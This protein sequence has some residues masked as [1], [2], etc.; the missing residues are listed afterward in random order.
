M[1]APGRDPNFLYLCTATSKSLALGRKLPADTYP[2]HARSPWSEALALHRRRGWASR[3]RMDRAAQFA[4]VVALFA[5]ACSP[6]DTDA[7]RE[8]GGA[9]RQAAGV[10]AE[11]RFPGERW[12]NIREKAGIGED[13]VCA[14]I[15]GQ[16][17]I[18]REKRALLMAQSD[19]NP[20]TWKTLYENWC[21]NTP[22][23]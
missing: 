18:Y 2:S 19:F 21:L 6:A 4:A 22:Y 10:A 13:A 3:S 15:A 1:S 23:R 14:E 17:I 9:L 20:D 16:Q 8:N 12:T 11:A 7:P 5:S